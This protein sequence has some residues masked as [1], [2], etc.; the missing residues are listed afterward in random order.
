MIRVRYEVPTPDQIA[1]EPLR[2]LLAT[3]QAATHNLIHALQT[4]RPVA[5]P[6]MDPPGPAPLDPGCW[7]ALA[8]A[9]ENLLEML[10]LHDRALTERHAA[11]RCQDRDF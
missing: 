7:T 4:E 6:A 2:P 9:L 8:L 5:F 1:E 3:V 10:N 11:C